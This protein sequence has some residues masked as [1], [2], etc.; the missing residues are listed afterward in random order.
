MSSRPVSTSIVAGGSLGPDDR[1]RMFALFGQWFEGY[2]EDYFAQEAEALDHC[3]LLHDE[4]TSELVGFATLYQTVAAVAGRTVGIFHTPHCVVDRAYWGTNE[5]LR[6]MVAFMF[7]QALRVRPELP[8][9][10]HYSAVGYRSYRYMPMLFERY[11]PRLDHATDAFDREVRDWV[12]HRYFG[13]YYKPAEGVVDWNWAG[14]GLSGMA[15]EINEAKLDSPA[16][17]AFRQVNPRWAE[18]VEIICQAR[19]SEDNATKVARRWLAQSGVLAGVPG[20]T[21]A[22]RAETV[23]AGGVPCSC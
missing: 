22:R 13:Q 5:L 9:Y 18:A 16:I 15:L 21:P 20:G 10:W 4:A 6:G 19:L 23:P 14:Y 1:R 8:W 12:G 17:A 7:D 2:G 3:I 11:T